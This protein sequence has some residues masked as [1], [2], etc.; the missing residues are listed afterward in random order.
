MSYQCKD[1]HELSQK[2]QPEAKTLFEIKIPKDLKLVKLVFRL[3]FPKDI[4]KVF[5]DLQ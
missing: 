2:Q 3:Y 5:I 1:N 4:F